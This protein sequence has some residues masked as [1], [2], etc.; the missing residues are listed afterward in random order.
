MTNLV[1]D[2]GGN[3]YGVELFSNTSRGGTITTGGT[4]QSLAPANPLRRGIEGQNISTGD[5]W[6]NPNG[7]AVV[8]GVGSYKVAAGEAFSFQDFGA[9]SIIGA[10]TGQKF[11]AQEL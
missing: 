1:R 6:I 10:T 8:D 4:A 9:I 11:T 7:T 5:L 2:L 3:G